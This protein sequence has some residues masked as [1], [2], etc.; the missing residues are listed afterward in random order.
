[1]EQAAGSVSQ[2]DGI[3]EEL[4]PQYITKVIEILHKDK[5][6][7]NAERRKEVEEQE[8]ALLHLRLVVESRLKSES[9]VLES[10]PKAEA[11][12]FDIRM[13]DDEA[14][15][16][17]M[18]EVDADGNGAISKEELFQSSLM[19]LPD[20]SEMRNAFEAA[21]GC[22]LQ[23]ME[24]ALAHLDAEDFGEFY[25]DN[26]G[27]NVIAA[28]DLFERKVLVSAVFDAAIRETTALAPESKGSTSLS[29]SCNSVEIDDMQGMES[30]LCKTG[31]KEM[32][33]RV[34]KAGL[35]RLVENLRKV[36]GSEKLASALDSLARLLHGEGVELDFLAVKRAVRRVP[37]VA[38]Q[39]ME[40]AKAVGLDG[41]L[42]RHIPP[43]SLEDGLAGLRGMTLD[44]AHLVLEAFFEDVKFKFLRAL[45]EAKTA[46]G[47]KSA[48]EANSKFADGFQ[49]SFASL[50]DFHAGAE[51]SLQLGYPNP[52]IEKGMHQEH[53]GHSSV[54]RL[55]LAPN[56]CIVTSLLIEYA[57]AVFEESPADLNA[58]EVFRR[59][60]DQL[61]M[62]A[63]ERE[64]IERSTFPAGADSAPNLERP[65][66]P[67]EVGD[68]FSE[69]LVVLRFPGVVPADSI[70]AKQF[71][72]TT[73]Q[74]AEGLLTKEEEK[75][76]GVS[77][78]DHVA[79]AEWS[80]R[81]ASVLLTDK[82][83]S[84]TAT[85][86]GPLLVGVLLPMS[87]ASAESKIDTLRAKVTNSLRLQIVEVEVTGCKTWNFTKYTGLEG[88]R[89]WL[90]EQSLDELLRF[91]S[92]NAVEKQSDVDSTESYK[93]AELCSMIIASFVRTELRS[94][95]RAALERSAS[96]A[97][98]E[99]LLRGWHL[100]PRS[101]ER[102]ELIEQ[103][104][105]ALDTGERWKMVEGWVRLYY[106]RIQGRTRLG[107]DVIML[108]EADKIKRC[109]LTKGEVLA[110]YLYTGPEFVPLNGIC[111]S[112]P[113]AIVKLLKGDSGTTADN[114][115]C[116]TLFCI[117][118]AIKK[119]SQ[120]TELPESRCCPMPSF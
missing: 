20:Q 76:R 15:L 34:R 23:T 32:I 80:M 73:K 30:K 109:G 53:T 111:R 11:L 5:D 14:V 46:T 44:K 96:D 31:Y 8:T 119:L 91:I 22:D 82:T 78:L 84:L 29:E 65:L 41:A 58:R 120:A 26:K 48:V 112:Y 36:S 9:S 33:N 101:A 83:G 27:K 43:G 51:A 37:R 52:D 70:K 1:M 68:S 59:A 100:E 74:C 62:L 56:Y 87:L 49:G 85:G 97:Q 18:C 3:M 61:K 39:R 88:L 93:H 54:T 10:S 50:R 4:C 63:K 106:G 19:K 115:L 75:V 81:S 77:I 98:I 104:A 57:W 94:D 60:L 116:T 64:S 47:S 21:F 110:L 72:D 105:G 24:D 6:N 16:R 28:G 103:A 55:F 66:F 99:A 45:L 17:L 25:H 71:Q 13:D 90:G 114:R 12:A 113:P 95:L 102:M 92:A 79:C 7:F 107:L 2:R 35:E 86:D 67:G 108:R 42:A 40:W 69:S 117:S 89:K 38:G 118:S